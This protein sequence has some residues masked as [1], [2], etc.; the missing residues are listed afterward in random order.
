H[1]FPTRRSSD[2]AIK[3]GETL[4]QLGSRTTEFNDGSLSGKAWCSECLASWEV[5]TLKGLKK[6]VKSVSSV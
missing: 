4:D 6:S 5:F 2:L 3:M 1:S